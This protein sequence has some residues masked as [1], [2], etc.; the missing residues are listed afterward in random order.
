MTDAFVLGGTRTAFARYG[1]ICMCIGSGPGVALVLQN[2][3][4][5]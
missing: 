5:G 3:Q 4:A 1:V 2:P